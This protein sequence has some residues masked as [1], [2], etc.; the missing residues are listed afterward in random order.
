MAMTESQVLE[1]LNNTIP[2]ERY[3]AASERVASLPSIVKKILDSLRKLVGTTGLD[4]G[5]VVAAART[6]FTTWTQGDD[7]RIPNWLEG[8]L[9]TAAWNFI[10]LSIRFMFVKQPDIN[11]V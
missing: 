7:P 9:E 2:R 4:V 5:V 10:E 8:M 3:G 1:H 11:I 6:Y